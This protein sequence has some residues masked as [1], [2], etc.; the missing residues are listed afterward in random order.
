[1]WVFFG[2]KFNVNRCFQYTWTVCIYTLA[3]SPPPHSPPLL[4]SFNAWLYEL[5]NYL[6]LDHFKATSVGFKVKLG[7]AI[8]YC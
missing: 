1:M 8:Q 7:V 3:S 2:Q 4:L 5:W 6:I